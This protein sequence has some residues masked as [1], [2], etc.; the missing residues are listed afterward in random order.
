MVKP[1]VKT[2]NATGGLTPATANVAKRCGVAPPV[3]KS[4]AEGTRGKPLLIRIQGSMRLG[5]GWPE[6]TGMELAVAP[7]FGR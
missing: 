7:E 5:V 6:L 1:P 3:A 4:G 2:V